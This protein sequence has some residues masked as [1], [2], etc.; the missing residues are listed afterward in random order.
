M[1]A[2]DNIKKLSAYWNRHSWWISLPIFSL[3]SVIIILLL[4]NVPFFPCQQIGYTINQSQAHM[5]LSPIELD[6]S[7]YAIGQIVHISQIP[8]D[9]DSAN[10]KKYLEIN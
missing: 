1:G 5:S 6:R 3:L 7:K 8:H 4:A 9:T 2:L 10:I